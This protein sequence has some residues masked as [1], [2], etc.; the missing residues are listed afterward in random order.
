MF[1][2]NVNIW[3]WNWICMPETDPD[4]AAQMINGKYYHPIHPD[5]DP[6][7]CFTKPIFD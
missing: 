3:I 4:P 7:P 1:K 6:P 5:P 2:Y